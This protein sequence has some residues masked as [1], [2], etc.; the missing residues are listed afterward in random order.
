MMRLQAYDEGPRPNWMR[1][2]VADPGIFTWYH[3]Q[4]FFE[5]LATD[6]S[7]KRIDASHMASPWKRGIPE[8]KHKLEQ[9]GP[10]YFE[11]P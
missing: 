4:C 5:S 11:R 3:K 6:Q 2:I 8:C 10:N 9:H 1:L 7:A